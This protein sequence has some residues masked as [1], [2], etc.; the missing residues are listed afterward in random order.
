MKI[1]S[2]SANVPVKPV[3]KGIIYAIVTTLVLVLV[4]A[5]VLISAPMAEGATKP[6]VQIIKVLSIFAGVMVALRSVEK[7]GWLYGG[8]VGLLYTV[9]AFFVFSILVA[10]FEISNGLLTDMIFAVAIGAISAMLLKTMRAS[11]V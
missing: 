9:L 10:E 6:I 11:A 7:N 5:G 3:A 4:F 1:P 2:F 8:I